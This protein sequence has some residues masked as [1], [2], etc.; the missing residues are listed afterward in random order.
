MNIYCKSALH[1]I[2]FA[3][4]T[5]IEMI[6]KLAEHD[7]QKRPTPGKYSI[8]ELLEHIAV[9]CKA[10]SLISD[11]ASQDKMNKFYLS[12]SYKSPNEMKDALIKNYQLLEDKFMNYT[13]VELHEKITSYW[14]V[15]YSRYEWLLEILA[16]VYHHRGQLNSMLVHC[17][18]I[19]PKVSLF[20]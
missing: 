9:I 16:H 2:K 8:G 18:G 12:V 1:Q 4:T 14:G 17:Y 7:L 5:I 20:E 13:E 10:D 6:E 3:L 19:E 15:T 11:G